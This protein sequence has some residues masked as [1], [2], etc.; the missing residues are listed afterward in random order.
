MTA[1]RLV[2]RLGALPLAALLAL[3]VGCVNPFQPASPEAP[4][5]APVIEDFKTPF[6]VLETM[7]AGI[8][9]R[10]INGANAYLHALADSTAAGDR[11]FRAFYDPAVKSSWESANQL[12][13]PEPWDLRLERNLH[14]KL[15]EIRPTYNYTFQWDLDPASPSDDDPNA[16]PDDTVQFHRHYTLFAAPTGGENEI[17]GIGFVDLSF[18]KESSGRWSIFRWHDRVDPAVGVNPAQPDQRT[19]SFWR[20]ESLNRR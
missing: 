8:E 1:P 6:K 14:S 2:L 4:S 16:A 19:F 7:Q 12:S 13:A 11:A 17:I 5:G 20:L 10:T 9:N 18:Q 3:P 15:S